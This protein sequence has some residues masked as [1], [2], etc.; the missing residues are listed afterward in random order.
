MMKFH[1][2]DASKKPTPLK[3][4]AGKKAA[5]ADQ[6]SKTFS[7]ADARGH[8]HQRVKSILNNARVELKHNKEKTMNTLFIVV[9]STDV[10]LAVETLWVI[11]SEYVERAAANNMLNRDFLFVQFQQPEQLGMFKS[12]YKYTDWARVC[13]GRGKKEE[14]EEEEDVTK[15]STGVYETSVRWDAALRLKHVVKCEDLNLR[16][17]VVYPCLSRILE[18]VLNSWATL[19]LYSNTVHREDR[20]NIVHVYP[21]MGGIFDVVLEPRALRVPEE[22]DHRLRCEWKPSDGADVLYIVADYITRDTESPF[23]IKEGEEHAATSNMA[24]HCAIELGRMVLLA[25][26]TT[27]KLVRLYRPPRDRSH[28]LFMD[29]KYTNMVDLFDGPIGVRRSPNFWSFSITNWKRQEKQLGKTSFTSPILSLEKI[30]TLDLAYSEEQIRKSPEN[31]YSPL[32]SS[33]LTKI[34]EEARRLPMTDKRHPWSSTFWL[35]KTIA[36]LVLPPAAYS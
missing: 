21:S 11:A 24:N 12:V 28:I 6:W 25:V 34:P 31:K 8:D 29:P 5:L 16:Y 1:H 33:G 27:M 20:E 35:W 23:I 9:C 19:T 14:E 7:T 36:T 18:G 2:D 22:G 10:A 26:K 30:M 15:L 4:N 3:W 32:I 17:E 13:S